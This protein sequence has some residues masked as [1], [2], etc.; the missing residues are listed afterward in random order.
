[1]YYLNLDSD[2]LDDTFDTI[3]KTLVKKK[4][5]WLHIYQCAEINHYIKMMKLVGSNVSHQQ[6][7]VDHKHGLPES[8][9]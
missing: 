9:W 1:M 3:F 7:Y 5:K 2:H 4:P 6:K 8:L